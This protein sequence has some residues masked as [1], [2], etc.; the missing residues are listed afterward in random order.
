VVTATSG[1]WGEEK[2]LI[3][4]LLWDFAQRTWIHFTD[5]SGKAIGPILKGEAVQEEILLGLLDP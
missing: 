5:V 3:L 4:P 2:N 1:R